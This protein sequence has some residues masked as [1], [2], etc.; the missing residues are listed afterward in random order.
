MD[1]LTLVTIAQQ[2]AK[3]D[4]GTSASTQFKY[5]WTTFCN[6]L[7]GKFGLG[8]FGPIKWYARGPV[9]DLVI[10]INDDSKTTFNLPFKNLKSFVVVVY[11]SNGIQ[12]HAIIPA[13][14]NSITVN[15]S[16]ITFPCIISA[17]N[18]EF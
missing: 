14:S 11:G 3:V 12:S 16:T 10:D 8:E 2:F 9:Y 13:S 7:K 5:A 18:I 1:N 15:L 6:A 17:N 4:L